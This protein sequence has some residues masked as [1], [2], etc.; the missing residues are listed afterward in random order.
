MVETQVCL[1]SL[2][3]SN[4]CSVPSFSILFLTLQHGQST[5]IHTMYRWEWHLAEKS[6]LTTQCE[7]LYF[8]V[9]S[10]LCGVLYAQDGGRNNTNTWIIYYN[11]KQHTDASFKA[12]D[13]MQELTSTYCLRWSTISYYT[14]V[15]IILSAPC[16]PR[17]WNLNKNN[18]GRKRTI[19]KVHIK[20]KEEQINEK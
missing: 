12:S 8:S 20:K 11:P 4:L 17:I 7:R 16:M 5:N 2:S 3:C 14:V 18:G 13:R 10:A 19:F 1:L 6:F 15:C 9:P